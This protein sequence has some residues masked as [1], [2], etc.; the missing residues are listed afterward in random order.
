MQT[1]NPI[2]DRINAQNLAITRIMPEGKAVMLSSSVHAWGGVKTVR[3]VCTLGYS[4][5]KS[6]T[7]ARVES[8]KC[9]N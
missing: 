7:A 5:P 1:N 6:E 9:E 4:L 3:M 2:Q 8:M